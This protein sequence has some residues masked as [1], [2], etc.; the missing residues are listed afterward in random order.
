MTQQ[1]KQPKL[2]DLKNEA[3]ALAHKMGLKLTQTAHFKKHCGQGLDLRTKAGWAKLIERL[4]S[5]S[6][7]VVV[8][9]LTQQPIAA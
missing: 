8:S 3:F 6:G 1:A 2:Q 5:L 4:Q 7:G 9:L